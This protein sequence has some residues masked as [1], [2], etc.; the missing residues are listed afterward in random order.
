MAVSK[1][2]AES[3]GKDKDEKFAVMLGNDCQRYMSCKA[4]LFIA[5]KKYL[6]SPAKRRELFSYADENGIRYFYDAEI[7]QQQIEA[8]RRRNRRYLEAE[9]GNDGEEID[10][11][12]GVVT[13]HDEEGDDVGKKGGE[14]VSI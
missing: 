10:T 3:T 6:V 4:E 2:N 8:A 13:L 11:A 14:S 12:A 5:G 9:E 1:R 7:I